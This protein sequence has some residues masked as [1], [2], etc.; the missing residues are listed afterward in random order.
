MLEPLDNVMFKNSNTSMY[1]LYK[2]YYI[3][4]DLNIKDHLSLANVHTFNND[5]PY[6]E[7]S[8]KNVDN[9]DYTIVYVSSI[10]LTLIIVPFLFYQNFL[11]F[12]PMMYKYE[13]KR[14]TKKLL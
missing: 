1:F 9:I 4:E 10:Y 5:L 7:I 2:S 12:I 14:Y 6:F 13:V 3:S 8:I 11:L